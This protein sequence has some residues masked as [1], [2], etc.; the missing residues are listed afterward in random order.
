MERAEWF[1][2]GKQHIQ[3]EKWK[4]L[5]RG[6]QLITLDRRTHVHTK[7]ELRSASKLDEAYSLYSLSG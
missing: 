1:L 4:S 3:T 2:G 5:L 6:P 7:T